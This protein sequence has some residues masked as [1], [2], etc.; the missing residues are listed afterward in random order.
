MLDSVK[1]AMFDG[2]S[3][4]LTERTIQLGTID[5]VHVQPVIDVLR[6]SGV[7]IRR[8]HVVR[9][10]LEDHFVE[11]VGGTRSVGARI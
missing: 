10:S 8:V 3:V 2:I 9:P 5:P 6:A 7:V 1:S 11:A 4:E